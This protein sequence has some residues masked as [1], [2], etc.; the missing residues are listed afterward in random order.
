MIL[1][2]A[3]ELAKLAWILVL[4][5]LNLCIGDYLI[6]DFLPNGLRDECDLT[7]LGVITTL[8]NPVNE[9]L[10]TGDSCL[11]TSRVSYSGDRWNSITALMNY[12]M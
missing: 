11:E 2:S 5:I 8:Y 3:I 1:S 4:S 12:K 7:N 9:F 6:G 10:V